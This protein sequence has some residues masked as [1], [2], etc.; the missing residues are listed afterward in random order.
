MDLSRFQF[1]NYQVLAVPVLFDNF[2]YL[3]CREGR[4]ILIDAGEA[5]PV[6]SVLEKEDLR[7]TDILITHTHHDHVGGCRAIVDR[8]GVQSISPGIE[9]GERISLGTI[10][11]A[12]S[13][14]GHVTVHKIYYFPELERLSFPLWF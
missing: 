8:L 14:P 12:I 3:I 13:T 10:C 6:F 7:L 11:R 2:A 5:K 9:A 1:S 4:A